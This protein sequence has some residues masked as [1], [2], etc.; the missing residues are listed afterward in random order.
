MATGV[1]VTPMI[2][3]KR[4]DAS[5]WGILLQSPDGVVLN[6]AM[7]TAVVA[8]NENDEMVGRM[9]LCLMPHIEGTW[10][11]DDYRSGS[12]GFRL[13][14]EMEKVCKELGV[15]KVMAYCGP[16]LETY[17]ERLGFTKAPV[18]VWVKEMET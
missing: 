18:S 5:N 17:M 13:E 3:V 10:V 11:R 6:P 7:T 1:M 15:S 14:K 12:V 4:L 16:E 9:Y 2:T 8:L